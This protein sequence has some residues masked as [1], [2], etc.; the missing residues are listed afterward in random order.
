MPDRRN[1]RVYTS[2]FSFRSFTT[3]GKWT[4]RVIIM[5]EI[6]HCNRKM[7]VENRSYTPVFGYPAESLLILEQYL[8]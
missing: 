1:R 3:M 7:V 2:H 6:N 8:T 5:R 4:V